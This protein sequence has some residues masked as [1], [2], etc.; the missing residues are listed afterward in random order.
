VR[1]SFIRASNGTSPVLKDLAIG[2][3]PPNCNGAYPSK[4]LLW[5]PDHK[6]KAINI[7]GVT[8]ANVGDTIAIVINSIKSDEKTA[9]QNGAGGVTK[10]PDTYGNNM[11]TAF[12]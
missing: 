1:V 10:V 6:F 8:D 12:V 3:T 4:E 11:S 9:T 2:N 7:Q 5:P